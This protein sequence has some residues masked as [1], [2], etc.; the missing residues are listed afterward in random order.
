MASNQNA[1]TSQEIGQPLP[2][3]GKEH[4]GRVTDESIKNPERDII[5]MFF[6][7][8]S[9]KLQLYKLQ[10]LAKK[11]GIPITKGKNKNGKSKKRTIKELQNDIKNKCN[12]NP[13]LINILV[14]DPNVPNP[15]RIKKLPLGLIVPYVNSNLVL[16]EDDFLEYKSERGD[17][18]RDIFIHKIPLIIKDTKNGTGTKVT[19]VAD[20]NSCIIEQ[21]IYLL[22]VKNEKGKWVIVK[23]GSFAETQ[24]MSKRIQSFGGGNYVTGSATNKWFQKTIKYLISFGLECHFTYYLKYV[25]PIIDD[26]PMYDKPQEIKPYLIRRVETKAFEVHNR[27][28]NGNCP[29]FGENCT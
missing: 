11:L 14:L 12:N 20:V 24:G 7:K 1:L 18:Y 21:G 13:E 9:L 25:K 16:R 26:D 15:L 29:I 5:Q 19:A 10:G 3:G 2:G 22:S 8:G 28:N 6:K 4:S 27:L 17:K 23:I